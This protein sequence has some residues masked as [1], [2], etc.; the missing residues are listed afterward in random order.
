MQNKTQL[1]ELKQIQG[2]STMKCSFCNKEFKPIEENQEVCE[3]CKDSVDELSNGK[4]E[5]EDE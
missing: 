4:G 5:D 3:N 2:G 1:E